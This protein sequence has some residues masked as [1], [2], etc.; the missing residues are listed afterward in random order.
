MVTDMNNKLKDKGGGYILQV[1]V[2]RTVI[3]VDFQDVQL[4]CIDLDQAGRL[5]GQDSG[6]EDITKLTKKEIARINA[7]TKAHLQS[8][9]STLKPDSQNISEV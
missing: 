9:T 4:Y 8:F 1:Y 2:I 6:D 7:G 5:I 3:K